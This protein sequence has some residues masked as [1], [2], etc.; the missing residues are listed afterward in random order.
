MDTLEWQ[1]LIL[2]SSIFQL[3]VSECIKGKKGKEGKKEEN[4]PEEGREGLAEL[5]FT[6]AHFRQLF[7]WPSLV[8]HSS[9]KQFLL[10]SGGL[11]GIVCLFSAQSSS[12][13]SRLLVGSLA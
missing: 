13:L 3:E 12:P 4:K 7:S 10:N 9:R 2:P 11:V 5:L 1:I 8:F 6:R